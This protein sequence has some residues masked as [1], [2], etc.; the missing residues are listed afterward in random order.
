MNHFKLESIINSKINYQVYSKLL[1]LCLFILFLPVDRS[2]EV[3]GKQLS[4]MAKAELAAVN[5]VG[6]DET[7]K[8]QPGI[9]T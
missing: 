3:N 6:S 2:L 4:D 8:N 1:L 9:Q 5:Q 7:Y